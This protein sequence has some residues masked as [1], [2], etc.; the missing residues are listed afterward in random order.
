MKILKRDG[1]LESLSFDK[2][3]HR[4]KK[5]SKDVSLGEL[6]T[7]DPDLIAQKTVSSIYD[8]IS[9]SEL[10]E[11]AARI[12]IGMIENIEYSQL[13]SRIIISNIQKNTSD[14][15]SHVIDMLYHNKDKT[16]NHAP[17]VTK[18][19][20]DII[21]EYK[22]EIDNAIDYKR[23]YLFEYFGYKTFEKSYL[24]RINGK[25]VER[26][27]HLYMR[28]AVQLHKTDIQ[29][30]IKTYDYISQHYYTFASPTNFNAGSKMN[31]LSSC[32]HE[33][34]IIGTVNRGPVKIKDVQIGDEVVTHLGNV[35]KVV[36]CH[37]NLLGNRKLYEIN[38]AKTKNIK[39]TD[40][41]NLWAL[42]GDYKNPEW[43]SVDNLKKGD[44]IG[45]PNKLQEYEYNKILDISQFKEMIEFNNI[46][47]NINDDI[48][49]LKSNWE[50]NNWEH[51]GTVKNH[52]NHKSIKR[53]WNINNNFA[54]FI[55][56]FYGDGHIITKKDKNNNIIIRGIGITI[57]NVNIKLIDFCKNAIRE[58]F[59]IDYTIRKIKNQNITQI[60]CHSRL[61]GMIFKH[62]FGIHFNNKKLW[63][64]IYN[65]DTQ[66]IMSLLEGMITTDGC[67]SKKNIITLQMSNVKFMRELYYLYRNNNI[68][69]SYGKIKKQKKA[70]EY[71][72]HMNIPSDVINKNNI[73]KCYNDDRITDIYSPKCKNQ[74][75]H[76]II[77]GFKFLKFEGKTEITD[78][79]PEYVYTLGVEDDH[80]YNIE[81]IIAQNCFLLGTHDSIEGIF[82]TLSDCARI[83]KVGGGIGI[84]ISNI[85]SKNSTI[86]GTNGSSDGIIPM[87]KVYNEC[88]LFVNQ[89][90]RRKGSFAIYLSP[91]HPDIMEF[92]DLRKN[93]GSEQIR[94]RDLFLAMWLPDLFMK[95]VQENGDWYLM[96]PDECPGLNDVYGDEYDK[97]YYSYVD[98]GMYRKKM[99]AQDIW[100]KILDS[101]MET[102]TPYLLYKDAI[103]KKS[104]QKNIGVI[105]SSNLCVSPETMILTSEGY[106]Q[107][108][109]LENQ[110]VQVWNGKDFS[111]TTVKKT[112]INQKLM[113]VYLSNGTHLTCTPYH[114]FYNERGH[115]VDAHELKVGT[116]LINFVLPIVYNPNETLE[117]AF[118]VGKQMSIMCTDKIDEE[119]VSKILKEILV[120]INYSLKSKIGWLNGLLQESFGFCSEANQKV[121]IITSQYIT[122]LEKI[123]Y[124]LQTLSCKPY[125]LHSE[126]DYSLIINE[127]DIKIL[128]DL[129]LYYIHDFIC[130]NDKEFSIYNTQYEPVHVTD[131]MYDHVISDTYCFKEQK[132]G[133]GIFNGI[134]TG[135]CAEITLY[136][137]DKE[138]AVCFTADTQI[139]TKNGYKRI[140]ECD[141]EQVLSI[142]NND[143]DLIKVEQFVHASL[144]DNGM[145]DVYRLECKGPFTTKIIKATSNH[146]F[147]TRNSNYTEEW[148]ELKNLNENDNI[149]L[150][151][152]IGKLISKTYIGKERVYDLNV[153]ETHNFVAEGFIVHNCNLSSIALPKYVEYDKDGKPFFNHQL[154][155]QVAKDMVLPMNRVI[156]YNYYPVPETEKSNMRHRPIGIGVQGLADAYIKMRY[157]FESDEASQLNKEIFETLYFATLT[158][159]MEL[160]KKEGPYST[161]EGSPF[162]EGKFQFDLWKEFDG[163]D[164]KDYIS[165]RWDWESLR[166]DVIKY[167]VRNSTLLTCMPTASSAQIMG[168]SDTMEP[169]DSCIYKKRVLSGEYIIANKYLVKEL[170]SLGLWNK[171]MKDT[172]IANNG[173]IQDIPGIPDDIKKLYKT[174]WS[175]SMK[176][177]I[178]QSAQRGVFIDMTQSCNL[179]M[180]SPNYKK[181]TSMHFYAWEKKLKTGIYYLRQNVISGGKFAIDPELEKKL[182]DMNI[183][184]LKENEQNEDNNCEMCSA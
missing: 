135:Q 23:D 5:L 149:C 27:Q 145:K 18:E 45:I 69:V 16:G 8:G 139:L 158:G 136:S 89:S 79:L 150:I 182:R 183:K 177:I 78:N 95:K 107:I 181:L 51:T 156:D 116:S 20:C 43:I 38:I 144:I 130:L 118:E 50:H 132:R 68:D 154:F 52:K 176:S 179:F 113:T 19:M 117:N 168:N 104:N 74:Y 60:L 164:L 13:A 37:K 161:F 92:L 24:L 12:A 112:G 42:T 66:M 184:S 57:H 162:S 178:N 36:Q 147:L 102:G 46:E 142:Y 80:S 64:E 83:S 103:N 22:N 86:R 174:V 106:Y 180:V 58:I 152:G 98:K 163:I 73:Y 99:K 115:K 97:L 134:L 140:D 9:S 88:A 96:C 14:K 94:A 160:A 120:P 17:I 55:G 21:Q 91:E 143:T 4:L 105:K 61:I 167:G 54:K 146:L 48:I 138:Y 171:Q 169:L 172:I 129:G 122:F 32:F 63:N 100:T 127:R 2:V 81:G 10:D 47:M 59:D 28:V 72:V 137:D 31:N 35:K 76:K 30:V 70:T 109:S 155:Y 26:P 148:K 62:L 67:I 128:T 165:G 40:N 15:F 25:V 34:T 121:I 153:P 124:L 71:H 41:H 49:T 44:Y 151:N 114:K 93:Q 170:T 77:N 108:A 123:L 125:I 85:R 166:Q 157:P 84:H 33:D 111:R 175:M 90:S 110:I 173:S 101:Q 75:S 141:N 56:I 1:T 131:I 39:V 82:K 159:S 3:L 53:Y 87:L 6:N 29:N 133:M 65:W 126:K 119:D 7:I 11:E